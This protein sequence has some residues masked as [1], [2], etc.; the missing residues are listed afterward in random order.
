MPVVT[1]KARIG[2]PPETA[3][4]AIADP[5]KPFLTLNPFTTTTVTAVC[6]AVEPHH[7]EGTSAHPIDL[8]GKKHA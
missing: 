6:S 4:S 8:L 2:A 3:F 1:V 5:R 7:Y